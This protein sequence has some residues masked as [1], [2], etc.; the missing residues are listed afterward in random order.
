MTILLPKIEV[1]I[2]V[3]NLEGNIT[4]IPAKHSVLKETRLSAKFDDIVTKVL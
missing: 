2:I 4:N 3:K 1:A